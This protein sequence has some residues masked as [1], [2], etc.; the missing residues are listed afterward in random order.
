MGHV[1]RQDDRAGGEEGEGAVIPTIGYG[2]PCEIIA[3]AEFADFALRRGDA[4]DRRIAAKMAGR[5]QA[6]DKAILAYY[7]LLLDS[8]L[9]DIAMAK[10]R[11]S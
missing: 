7:R 3:I 9:A 6:K 2:L 5:W 4:E 10:M 8:C 1:R 11:T